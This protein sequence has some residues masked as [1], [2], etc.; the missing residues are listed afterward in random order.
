[1]ATTFTVPPNPRHSRNYA[2]PMPCAGIHA[3]VQD[4]SAIGGFSFWANSRHRVRHPRHTHTRPLT[5]APPTT[6]SGGNAKH[7]DTTH[8]HT[9]W[10]H[11]A[12]TR[13]RERPP[14][15]HVFCA[16]HM[17]HMRAFLRGGG[18]TMVLS[19]PGLRAAPCCS[20]SGPRA[21]RGSRDTYTWEIFFLCVCVLTGVCVA[22]G[23]NLSG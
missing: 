8:S 22:W 16:L 3:S 20:G 7:R 23:D 2:C 9:R 18:S 6:D 10:A 4:P 11:T 5:W 21:Q 12:H 15:P 17:S 14:P 19:I 13:P 1:M